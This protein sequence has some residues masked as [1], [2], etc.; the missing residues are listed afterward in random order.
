MESFLGFDFA[1][2]GGGQL[3]RGSD[4]TDSKSEIGCNKSAEHSL[5]SRWQETKRGEQKKNSQEERVER[6]TKNEFGRGDAQLPVLNFGVSPELARRLGTAQYQL[7][8]GLHDH[9]K[10]GVSRTRCKSLLVPLP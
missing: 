5:K 9:P 3:E 8:G 7:P 2:L 4:F 6:D 10:T 1:H